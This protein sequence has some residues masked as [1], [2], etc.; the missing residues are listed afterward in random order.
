MNLIQQMCGKIDIH[1]TIFILAQM[2]KNYTKQ[3]GRSL[4][5]DFTDIGQFIG[6]LLLSGYHYVPEESGV[7][8]KTLK[9]RL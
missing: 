9:S 1:T 5:V 4:D 7:Q 3:K 6:I 2:T 8:Q